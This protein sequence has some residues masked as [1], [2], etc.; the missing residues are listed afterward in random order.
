MTLLVSPALTPELGAL[1]ARAMFPN[2]ERVQQ[3]LTAYRSGAGGQVF[4]WEIGG[5]VVSAAGV[6]LEAGGPGAEL[7][8]IG[9]A[10]AHTGRGYGR[11]LVYAAAKALA[12]RSIW[13]Q[14]DDG[15]V[16]FYRR[17]GF[18]VSAVPSPWKVNRYLCR[19]TLP[20]AAP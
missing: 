8:H 17:L 10:P 12:V 19:L 3:E 20:A 2:P 4:A 16:G 15:A 13:A 7:R 11:A 9:T 14:T 6:H 1:L 5:V 18:V